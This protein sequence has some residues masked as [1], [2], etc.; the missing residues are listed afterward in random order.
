MGYRMISEGERGHSGVRGVSKGPT[1][2]QNGKGQ[3]VSGIS[4]GAQQNKSKASASASAAASGDWIRAVRSL[5]SV[6]C[7]AT[8]G[9]I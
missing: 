1:E 7:G 9:R 8:E 3:D 4:A 5:G 6:R 2:R